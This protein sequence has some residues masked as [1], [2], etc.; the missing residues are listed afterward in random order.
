MLPPLKE[1]G[2][3]LSIYGEI[4]PFI[5]EF[6]MADSAKITRCAILR[7]IARKCKDTQYGQTEKPGLSGKLILH[8]VRR[9][10]KNRYALVCTR[11]PKRGPRQ[12]DY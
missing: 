9:G 12:I 5:S 8:F 2:V 4:P 6:N 7:V 3:N 11:S 1:I 10:S